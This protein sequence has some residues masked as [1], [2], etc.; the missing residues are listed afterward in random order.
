MKKKI[1][2]FTF[3]LVSAFLS[4]HLHAGK[5]ELVYVSF[6]PYEDS[7]DGQPAG[8]L[9]QIVEL[10]FKRADIEYN[11]TFLPFKRG[12][13][14]VK[15]G[16]FDGIFNF[17]KIDKRLP[18]FDYSIP[19]I[20]NPLVF[21]VRRDAA[22]PYESIDDLAGKKI[23]V[24]IGYTYG[25]EFDEADH[26]IKDSA[27]EHVHNF[28]KVLFGRL[29]AYPCDKMVGIY[30]ARKEGFMDEFKILAH[31]LKVMDGHIGFTKGKH[32]R[33]IEKINFQIRNMNRTGEIEQIIDNFILY[34]KY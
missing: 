1:I 15:E 20:K 12:Y 18:Y 29:D 24:M 2:L 25:K 32:T 10:A 16:R 13:D 7:V 19:I 9:V 14:L 27:S 31:P 21:F 33:I 4:S 17:Y 28:R 11:L 5:I 8:I 23:G 22:M 6:P 30:I 3:F 26:F 34:D